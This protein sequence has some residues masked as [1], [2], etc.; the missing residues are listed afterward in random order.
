M[1]PPRPPNKRL[2]A[3]LP[4]G[5]WIAALR[6][7]SLGDIVLMTP[8]LAALKA[9]RP[10]LRLAVVVEPR[11]A[12]AL[13][14]NPDIERVILAPAGWPARVRTIAELRRLRPALAVGLH[15]GSTAAVL[16]RFSSAPERAT[17]T[18]LRHPWA[19]THFTTPP[20]PPPG[21][22]T[23]HAAEHAASLFHALGLPPVELG[24]ARL[25]PASAARARLRQ[26]LAA[27]NVTGPFA[28]LNLDAREPRMRWPRARFAALAA[29]LRTRYGWAS[30]SATAS[31]APPPVDGI[32]I[33]TATT[34]EELIALETEATFVAGNDGGP[35]HIAAALGKPVVGLYSSTDVPVWTPWRTRAAVLEALPIEDLA[36]D[37]V[38]SAI[39]GL[40][41]PAVSAHH[42]QA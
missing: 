25:F 33:V 42:S 36:L 22:T 17:F 3:E 18:G 13:A 8:A 31:A 40:L 6:L 10:D 2:L 21:R 39:T 15:G 27:L 41:D 5:A 19:Y 20:P 35:L 14:G 24:P 9:W 38:Q 4:S 34:V 26:R 16:A 12:A 37:A 29:W 11:F 1:T 30:V 28:F 32:T 7:R 23:L